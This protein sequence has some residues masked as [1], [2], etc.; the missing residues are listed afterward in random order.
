M[1][2]SQNQLIIENEQQCEGN[3]SDLIIINY[4]YSNKATVRAPICDVIHH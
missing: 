3:F 2:H 4:C 1:I